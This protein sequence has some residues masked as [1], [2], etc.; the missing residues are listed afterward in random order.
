MQMGVSMGQSMWLLGK[1]G[2]LRWLHTKMLER[3]ASNLPV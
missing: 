1:R 2:L 3:R